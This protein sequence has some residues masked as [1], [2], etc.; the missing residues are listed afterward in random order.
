MKLFKR[1][2]CDFCHEKCPLIPFN[3]KCGGTFCSI[4]RYSFLHFCDYD[5]QSYDRSKISL[6]SAEAQRGFFGW[7]GSAE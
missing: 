7:G 2:R 1:K 5:H 3:C 4:H 6:S